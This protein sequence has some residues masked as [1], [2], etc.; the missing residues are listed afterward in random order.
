MFGNERPERQEGNKARRK[1]ETR[2]GQVFKEQS[3]VDNV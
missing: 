3:V 2:E 1:A